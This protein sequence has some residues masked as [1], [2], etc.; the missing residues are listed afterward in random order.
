MYADTLFNGTDIVL[1]VAY[2]SNHGDI[3]VLKKVFQF[4]CRPGM[5]TGPV[6]N[7]S[8]SFVKGAG[9][10]DQQQVMNKISGAMDINRGG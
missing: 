7:D 9:F 5:G 3:Q 2:S 1:G 4:I 10:A 8:Q 6:G